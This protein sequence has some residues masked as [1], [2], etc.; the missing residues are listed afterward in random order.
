[1]A[2]QKEKDE[3]PRRQK[4]A[5]MAS[6]GLFAG[7]LLT[8]GI[9][10]WQL[11]QIASYDLGA[12]VF[13][14]Y[15]LV[16]LLAAGIIFGVLRGYGT[17]KGKKFGAAIEFGGAAAMCLCVLFAGM[18]FENK[19]SDVFEI[20]VYLIGDDDKKTLIKVPGTAALLLDEPKNV[21]FAEG[22]AIFSK[23]PAKNLGENISLSVEV[24]GYEAR[25]LKNIKFK[26]SKRIYVVLKAV[27]VTKPVIPADA[28]PAIQGDPTNSA[29]PAAHAPGKVIQETATEL[30]L[31]FRVRDGTAAVS[32]YSPDMDLDTDRRP[33]ID[34]LA[35]A[36]EQK[37]L[38]NL[39]WYLE[40]YWRWP[41]GPDV[42]RAR[43][44][45][46]GLEKAGRKLFD[47]V[48]GFPD[49]IRIW[50]QFRDREGA[51]LLTI[52]SRDP[53]ILRL[54]WELLA[55]EKSHLF[56]LDISVRR[57][58]HESKQRLTGPAFKPPLRILMVTA[59]PQDPATPFIDPRFS[60]KALLDAADI[61][62]PDQAVVEFLAPATFKALSRRLRQGKP[63]HVVHFDGHGV[64][65]AA[66]NLGY[67]AFEN[68]RGGLDNVDA[69]R[70]GLLMVKA[71]T[72]L[73]V[74]DAC[75]SAKVGG[76]DPFRGVAPR[77]IEAGAGGVVAMP[78]SVLTKT[79]ERF[80]REFY[81]ALVRGDTIGQAVDKGRWALLDTPKRGEIHHPDLGKIDILLKDWF[82]P[83]LY[84]RAGDP[85]PFAKA[86]ETPPQQAER[87]CKENS[88]QVDAA[89]LGAFPK[90]KYC[91]IGRAR[92]LWQLQRHL[93]KHKIVV[94][95]GLAG[96]G[97]TALAAETARWLVRSGRFDK[98]VFISFEGGG[99]T[100]S[101]L[102]QLGRALLGDDFSALSRADRLP[103]LRKIL[104]RERVLIIWDNFE[105]V[106][107]G[108]EAQQAEP[109]LKDLLETGL[110]LARGK[111]RLL[112]T[113]RDPKLAPHHYGYGASSNVAYLPLSGMA[114]SEALEL[115]G[116][117]LDSR[118]LPRPPRAGLKK[119]LE[120]LGGHP[121][122]ILLVLPHLQAHG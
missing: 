48:F 36:E 30:R 24:N 11:P 91:F 46:Q 58:V 33:F 122:S 97:K 47:A 75:Q 54:P 106:L 94:V 115:A 8:L 65:K 60:A 9:L 114:V 23:I 110:K 15:V 112:I 111:A 79:A 86:D 7:L 43:R 39:R 21:S 77:L 6:A 108:W 44:A 103:A 28:K 40:N 25:P 35:L 93:D 85:A 14:V 12:P 87:G 56:A 49:G 61:L 37:T 119:L 29:L 88:P 55:D 16:S 109:V 42:L 89:L 100:D 57:R 96:Q 104:D 116:S 31:K 76:P 2:Q 118:G 19:K 62:G 20:T 50:Q 4:S 5:F 73:L 63:V 92:E 95:H 121:L 45:E 67:L 107:P 41:V 69:A 34:P 17:V 70:L 51:K 64:Y 72:P 117:V 78:Y 13:I 90:P 81:R 10:L 68:E 84:Q 113:S 27:N 66:E 101:A 74:L 18:H 99:D 38:E 80:F 3:L 59:R 83:V 1:M 53:E 26:R 120:Y 102:G 52:D 105:S 32:L 71:K 98:A 22:H 82:L